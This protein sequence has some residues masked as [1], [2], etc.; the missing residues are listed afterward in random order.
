MSFT[1]QLNWRYATKKFNPEKPVTEESLNAILEAIRLAPTSFGLQPFHVTVVSKKEIQEQLKAVSWNQEQLL[2]P[3]VLVFS[4]RSDVV[5]RIQELLNLISGG[6]AEAREKLKGYEDMMNGS[7]ASRTPDQIKSWS[8]KQAYIALGFA[9]AACAE[10]SID[11]CPMEGFDSEAFK[12]ILNLPENLNP[13]VILP[14]G[15]R[16]DDEAPHAKVRFAKDEM[17]STVN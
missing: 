7:L 16:A 3:Y 8:A 2:A 13:A 4:G 14:I 12:K 15:Y 1:S 11:S 9:L 5:P 10:L 17:F 6:N